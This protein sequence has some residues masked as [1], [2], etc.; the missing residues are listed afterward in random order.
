MC[1]ARGMRWSCTVV[2]TLALAGCRDV[3]PPPSPPGIHDL[4]TIVVSEQGLNA[5][6]AVIHDPR[7]DIYLVTN[8]P[9]AHG[10][11]N[12]PGFVARV[13]PSGKVLSARWI[14]GGGRQVDLRQPTAM[15]IR[16]DTLFVADQTCVRLFHRESGLSRGSICP[17]GAMQLASL[18]VRNG[19]VYV[20]DRNATPGNGVSVIA[21]DSLGHVSSVEGSETL[22]HPSGIA[23]GPWGLFVTRTGED[24]VSQLT[25]TGPRPVLR[26]SAKQSGGIVAAR[27]GSF[28][29]SNSTDSAV[30]YVDVR[31]A[32]GRGALYTLARQL[33]GPGQLGYDVSRDRVLIPEAGRNRVTFVEMMNSEGAFVPA[34]DIK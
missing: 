28:A 31:F 16:G 18:T 7:A 29:F 2:S 6:T 12:E 24:Y 5:P 20:T 23:A 4:P 32:K 19:I 34:Y 14:D 17:E 25:R 33:A 10:M 21:I 9:A 27:A 1:P 15:T 11:A 13:A 3:P 26:G 8:A 30:H 22:S